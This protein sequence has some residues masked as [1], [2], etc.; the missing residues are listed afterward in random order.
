MC[1]TLFNLDELIS[2]LEKSSENIML[3]L[4]FTK[5]VGEGYKTYSPSIE[6]EIFE[7][8]LNLIKENLSKFNNHE[9]VYFSPVGYKEGTIE[10]CNT[11]YI[12]KY[13]QLIDLFYNED[14]IIRDML[15]EEDVNSLNFYT[16]KITY[17]DDI[18]NINKDILV[19]RRIT[20]FRK[21]SKSGMFGS[22]K[23]NSFNKIDDS[24]I[25]LDG[26]VDLI[27]KDGQI[28]ILN[29]VSLERIFSLNSQYLENAQNAIDIIK[30][31]GRISPFDEFEEDCL[32]DRRVTRILTKML[33]ED[34]NLDNCFE[35]FENVVDVIDIFELKINIDNTGEKGII[36]YEDKSQLMDVIRLVRDSYYRSIIREEPG[37]DDSI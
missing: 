13:D 20:K 2:I 12:S 7:E 18:E 23:N 30:K 10:V 9:Q 14:L 5:K 22:I 26:D 24:L 15:S 31:A 21:L 17:F 16:I 37:V 28:L 34:D 32:N 36:Q 1:E 8:L 25:G 11:N 29:H 19:F 6:T 4:Y 35:N 33:S 3:R 27:V